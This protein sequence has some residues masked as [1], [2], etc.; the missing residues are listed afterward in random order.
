MNKATKFFVV[1]LALGVAIVCVGMGYTAVKNQQDTTTT[2]ATVSPTTTAP[3]TE[4]TTEPTTTE[5]APE[6]AELLIGKWSDSAQMSGFEFFE[7]GKVSFT[8]AN[9]ASLGISFDGKLDNGTYTLNGNKLTIAYSIYSAT[10]DNTYEISIKDDVLTL[11]KTDDSKTS[12]FIRTDSFDGMVVQGTSTPD[13]LIGSWE[14]KSLD[15]TYKFTQ[16]GKVT[17]NSKGKQYEGVY[18]TEGTNITIQYVSGVQKNT[19]K[20]SFAV[21]KNSLALTASDGSTVNYS[22]MGTEVSTPANSGSL[23]GVWRDSANLSG[24]EFKEGEV[25]SVTF[26]NFTIPVIDKPINGTFTG[27]YEVNNGVVSLTYYIYGVKISSSYNYEISGNTLKLT[28]TENGKVST[29]IKQ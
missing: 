3:T 2:V 25:V 24:Y 5:K 11:K 29:Y 6:L 8:Y 18:V 26:V 27:G 22:R 14:N 1:L 19:E 7:D 17:I 15:K 10:I 23:L 13:E 9:L 16:S 4:A 20:Y 21:T 28:D 12:T